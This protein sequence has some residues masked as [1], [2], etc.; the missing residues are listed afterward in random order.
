MEERSTVAFGP[1][2]LGVAT[3][4]AAFSLSSEVNQRKLGLGEAYVCAPTQ[5]ADP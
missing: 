1:A 3:S 4:V 5:I 2:Q